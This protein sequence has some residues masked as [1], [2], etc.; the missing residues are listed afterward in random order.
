MGVAW[1]W[2]LVLMI[3]F[4]LG[5]AF[6]S[7]KIHVNLAEIVTVGAVLTFLMWL[8]SP[9]LFRGYFLSLHPD[10]WGYCATAEYL[11][12]FV[13]GTRPGIVPLYIFAG[14]MSDARLGTYSILGFLGRVLHIDAAY[15]VAYYVAFLLVNVFWGVALLTRLYGAKPLVSLLAGSYAVVCGLIPDTIIYGALDN[16]LFLSV[17]PFVIIRLHLF[18]RGDRSLTSIVGLAL[19]ASAAFYA[20]PEGIAVAGIIFLPIFA[21][22]LLKLLRQPRFSRCCLM[23]G[24]FFLFF[25]APYLTTFCSFVSQQL[26]LNASVHRVG[27]NAL[28]GLISNTFLPS[29]F[30]SGDE[31]GGRFKA[32]HIVLAVI[33]LGLLLFGS[34]RQRK[35]NR[36]AILTSVFLV[37]LC[38]LGLGLW[39]H[40]DYGLFKVLIVSS[41]L[42]TPLIFCG[43]QL[44]WPS[45]LSKNLSSVAPMLAFFLAL[46]AFEQRREQHRDYFSLAQQEIRPY[47]ELKKIGKIVG[48]APVK[49]VFGGGDPSQFADGIDQLWAA[50]FLRDLNLDIPHPRLY[51]EGNL[52][53]LPY[54]IWREGVDSS[55]KFSLFNYPQKDAIWSNEKFSLTVDRMDSP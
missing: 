29:M 45:S 17:F 11:T 9:Y 35:E 47:A 28:P 55:T 6:W 33:C 21:F 1:P 18:V 48:Q 23:L 39:L 19:S 15:G 24:G 38:A 27:Q 44:A 41:L 25:V 22:S 32:S 46:T 53:Y 4:V 20:Y 14:A 50:Y 2:I 40:Y 8:L 16:L 51:L 7:R 43:I 49:L 10:A 36:V 3:L 30:G 37:F 54:K 42:T 31:F 13:R 26:Y 12:R 5:S 34:V 52:E